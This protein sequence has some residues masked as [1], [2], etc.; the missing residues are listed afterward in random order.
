[1][2]MGTSAD[3]TKL[4]TTLPAT[5]I[6]LSAATLNTRLVATYASGSS[7]APAQSEPQAGLRPRR[8]WNPAARAGRRGQEGSDK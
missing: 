4:M 3:M 8:H 1:M 5:R 2:V 6:R 7:G